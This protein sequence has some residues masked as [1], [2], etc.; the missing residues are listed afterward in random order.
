MAS[1]NNSSSWVRKI[2]VVICS[3][4]AYISLPLL[5]LLVP[6]YSLRIVV[7]ILAKLFKRDLGKM[8]TPRS[9]LFASEYTEMFKTR[10]RCSVYVSFLIDIDV[11]LETF[12]KYFYDKVVARKRAETDELQNPE[13]QQTITNFLGYLF[14][15]WDKNFS[16]ENHVKLYKGPGKVEH[17]TEEDLPLIMKD[18]AYRPFPP[19]Q[20]P[21]DIWIWDNARLEGDP[22]EK[23]KTLYI[24]RVHHSL[25]DGFAILRLLVEDIHGTD[26]PTN[27][28][29]VGT[30][31]T[32][33]QLSGWNLI[34]T[35]MKAPYEMVSVFIHS[36]DFNE[37]RLPERKLTGKLN[38]C[39]T[40]CIPVE[41]MKEI[42]RAYGT[43]YTAVI[44][45]AFAGGIRNFML[46]K[47]M[48]VPRKIHCVIPLPM[49]GHPN[50]LRNHV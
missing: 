16:M 38:A 48:K 13:M 50:K 19:G 17:V 8:L 34:R 44:F 32:E 2:L 30:K 7:A 22:E 11:D 3:I 39:L 25:G 24:L 42:K 37:W 14:W 27:V 26:V 28:F 23:R 29:E 9:N 5:I 46:E 41:T 20:S 45:A 33:K 4:F 49:P 1:K 10:T 35:L 18:L 21:W 12:K 43:S 31:K 6:V 36:W 47:N 40:S 15:K